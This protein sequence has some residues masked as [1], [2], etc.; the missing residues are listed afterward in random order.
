M[1]NILFFGL[2]LGYSDYFVRN[3]D[4][5]ILMERKIRLRDSGERRSGRILVAFDIMSEVV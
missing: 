2:E 1:V 3:L 5:K 4:K